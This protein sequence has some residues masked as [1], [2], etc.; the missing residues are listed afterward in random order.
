MTDSGAVAA[1]GAPAVSV[2]VG[3]AFAAI[4]ASVGGVAAL[5]AAFSHHPPSVASFVGGPVPVSVGVSGVP[6]PV[7]PGAYRIQLRSAFGGQTPSQDPRC[8]TSQIS[9]YV[10]NQS[11][12]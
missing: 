1:A 12:L 5:A 7:A 11:V 4:A 10:N 3:R 6:C 9:E 2:A 8:G